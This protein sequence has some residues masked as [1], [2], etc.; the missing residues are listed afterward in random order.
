MSEEVFLSFKTK[1]SIIPRLGS[2]QL[3]DEITAVME[4]VK[5]A[6][7]A[8]AKFVKIEFLDDGEEKEI[9]IQDDGS[10]MTLGDLE[11]NWASLGTENKLREPRS[12]VFKRRRLGQKGVGR[13]ATEKLG[14]TLILKTRTEE[15][16]KSKQVQ[17]D[18]DLISGEK[19]LSDYKY[20]ISEKKPGNFDPPN[21]TCLHIK[22]LRINWNKKKIEKLRN[23]LCTLIDPD[24]AASDFKIILQSPWEFLNGELKN[25]LPGNETHKLD[26]ELNEDGEEWVKLTTKKGER[27][28]NSKL[29][30]ASFGPIRGCL[31]YYS[32]GLNTSE[33]SKGDSDSDWNMGVRIFRDGCRVRPYGEYGSEGDWLQIYKTKYH[34]GGKQFRLRPN[35]LEGAIHISADNN[36]E[37][38]DTTSREGIEENDAFRNLVEYVYDKVMELSE[39]IADEEVKEERQ[40]NQ[41]RY[42]KVLEPL[43]AG[44]NTLHSEIYK[45][46]VKQWDAEVKK[47]IVAPVADSVI[48]NAHWACLDCTD[49]WKVPL[50]KTP[51]KCREF[52]VGRDGKPTY[53]QG[54]GSRNI[55][56]KENLTL[57]SPDRK[58]QLSDFND[59]LAGATAYIS[60]I[61]IK[62]IIDWE[63]GENDEEAEV[64]PEQRQLAINGKHR[65]FRAAEMLDGEINIEGTTYEVLKAKGALTM[66]VIDAASF[67]WGYWHFIKGSNELNEFTR[68]YSGLKGACLKS[69]ERFQ[70]NQQE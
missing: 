18:W 32:Q 5:N 64:R 55:C 59:I 6:Y 11:N 20:P 62:P 3:K 54:C 17:F 68:Q 56:R 25:P 36:P 21:G 67:A 23:Q 60:D 51:T 63:M 39:V 61:Q 66:H 13:F 19:E 7:D 52:S 65:N 27:R 49:S 2:E 44:L 10:G 58:G 4:L 14:K 12:P 57:D 47:K 28:G 45:K 50:E 35:Y 16:T 40:R 70:E 31:R 34:K 26:F 41:E 37:L 33:R 8:D 24:A 1:G 9:K 30:T 42:N 15:D 29:E 69:L 53:K 46:A 43:T 38:R 22:R 48:R